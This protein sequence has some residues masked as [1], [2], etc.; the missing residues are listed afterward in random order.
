[1]AGQDDHRVSRVQIDPAVQRRRLATL[2]A[3]IAQT[4]DCVADTLERLALTRPY[5]EVAL[6]ARAAHARQQADL[7]RS[8]AATFSQPRQPRSARARPAS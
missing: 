1:M 8:Q 6:L 7:G 3:N 2:A 4:E 5:D